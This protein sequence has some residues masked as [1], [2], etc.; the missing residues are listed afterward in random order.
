LRDFFYRMGRWLV[1]LAFA[2][3]VIFVF[4][5]FFPWAAFRF[6][7]LDPRLPEAFHYH[8]SPWIF[9]G[10]VVLLLSMAALTAPRLRAIL[11]RHRAIPGSEASRHEESRGWGE[12]VAAPLTFP[13]GTEETDPAYFFLSTNERAVKD[14]FRAAGVVTGEDV[15]LT[16]QPERAVLINAAS[17]SLLGRSSEVLA[18]APDLELLCREL[19]G[20]D[21]EFP[22]LRGVFV[23]IPCDE[24]RRGDPASMARR[25]HAD[26]QAIRR[27]MRLDVP[28]YLVVTR[29]EQIPGFVEFAKLRGQHEARQGRWGITLARPR[30]LE[31]D[32]SWRRL[33][34]FRFR[35]RRW[36]LDL[37]VKDPLDSDRNARLQ[38]LD[39]T[40]ASLITSL[41]ALI[42]AAFPA[43][44]K[45]RPFLRAIDL[46]AT[47]AKPEE[48][49]YLLSS[50]YLPII[51]DGPATRWT[52]EAIDEDQRHRRGAL[53]IA[54]TTGT[55][56][57][58]AWLYIQFG[59]GSLDRWGWLILVALVAAWIVSLVVMCRR[60]PNA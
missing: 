5:M 44:E 1:G 33:V 32:E 49:A 26:L 9:W 39:R 29:M 56:T 18:S 46:T 4:W 14:L 57:L 41:T 30:S 42:A 40:L 11:R 27:V 45:E 10:W 19:L 21:T 28:T 47:G 24:L 55:F 8:D 34:D 3:A 25:L 58:L 38:G 60:W 2:A 52:L 7:Q 13:P 6:D 23:V 53:R 35:V 50:V 17:S 12:P 31:E 43:G 54:A 15:I 37:L 51:A 59:L 22:P 36:T 20:R 48:Q 16:T